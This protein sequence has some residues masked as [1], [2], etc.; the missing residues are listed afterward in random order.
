MS[1][2]YLENYDSSKIYLERADQYFSVS[3]EKRLAILPYLILSNKKTGNTARSEKLLTLFN[4]ISQENDAEKKDYIIANWASY[5]AM[6]FLG[7]DEEA[8]GFLE[9]AYFEIKSRSRDIKNKTDR[10]KYLATNLHN[11][12]SRAWNNN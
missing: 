5:E 2:Y 8:K 11:K 7:H 9:N 1:H 3:K 6:G 10:N 4:E 12:I